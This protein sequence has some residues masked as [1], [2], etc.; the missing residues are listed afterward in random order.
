MTFTTP[1]EGGFT[2]N[3][4]QLIEWLETYDMNISEFVMSL[5]LVW[6]HSKCT[7][8]D[9]SLIY[10]EWVLDVTGWRVWYIGSRVKA[11]FVLF[12]FV[13][14]IVRTG[15]RNHPQDEGGHWMMSPHSLKKWIKPDLM[16]TESIKKIHP[17]TLSEIKHSQVLLALLFFPCPV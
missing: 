4:I 10:I 8:A 12:D 5:N 1:L 15:R 3:W 16:C 14:F 9:T 6:P 7:C 13:A 2:W 11:L 17:G